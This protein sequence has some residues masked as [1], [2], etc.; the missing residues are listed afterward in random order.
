MPRRVCTDDPS[1][2][3]HPAW[4]VG[5][6]RKSRDVICAQS[7][8]S[9]AEARKSECARVSPGWRA[10]TPRKIPPW[11]RFASRHGVTLRRGSGWYMPHGSLRVARRSSETGLATDLLEDLDLA[12]PVITDDARCELQQERHDD[13]QEPQFECEETH[14][15]VLLGNAEE[16]HPFPIVRI[17]IPAREVAPGWDWTMTT[18][19]SV[20]GVDDATSVA[21]VYARAGRA[22]AIRDGGVSTMGLESLSPVPLRLDLAFFPQL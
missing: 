21:S 9:L 14:C 4:V 20:A 15:V 17:G 5:P 12:A 8:A 3:L 2:C 7:C 19:R 22:T 16:E 10:A 13:H 11:R 6:A 1:G 18:D